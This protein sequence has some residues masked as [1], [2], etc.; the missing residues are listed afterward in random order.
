ML[1]YHHK[2]YNLQKEN[3]F[4]V[5]KNSHG[6]VAIQIQKQIFTFKVQKNLV[7]L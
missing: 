2:K 6:K 1:V 5:A 7:D 4:V 3:A